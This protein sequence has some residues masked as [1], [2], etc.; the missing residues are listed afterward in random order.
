MVKTIGSRKKGKVYKVSYPG[1]LKDIEF[2]L[3]DDLEDAMRE[4][5]KFKKKMYG[6][7]AE[8]EFTEFPHGI[9]DMNEG[10]RELL[11]AIKNESP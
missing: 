9:G 10:V 11:K 2:G 8:V 6:K 4:A 3:A 7:S 1:L 5:I